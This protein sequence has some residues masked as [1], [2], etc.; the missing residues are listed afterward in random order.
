MNHE[1]NA[2]IAK[3]DCSL[4]SKNISIADRINIVQKEL[5]KVF[6]IN[7]D[8]DYL[9]TKYILLWIDVNDWYVNNYKI[10]IK[11]S[12]FITKKPFF[13]QGDIYYIDVLQITEYCNISDC[14]NLS[15]VVIQDLTE[16]EIKSLR[17]QFKMAKSQWESINNLQLV[18]DYR[19]ERKKSKND[20]RI[21]DELNN[22]FYLPPETL[23]LISLALEDLNL[24]IVTLN[25]TSTSNYQFVIFP[26]SQAIEKLLKACII[27]EKLI[28][29]KE[30]TEL[31]EILKSIK[32][33]HKLFKLI[34][35]FNN[36]LP[37]P[38]KIKLEINKFL[39]AKKMFK[40]S[41]SNPR[42]DVMKVSPKQAVDII[43]ANLNI[44]ELVSEKFSTP[45][46]RVM[47][48]PEL[49]EGYKEYFAQLEDDDFFLEN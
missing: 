48:Y 16:E 43:D 46:Y 3:I 13:L 37:S 38:D 10:K 19:D 8:Y 27:S 26:A 7:I 39:N 18:I 14:T 33:G 23:D 5:C 2:Q 45:L 29:G 44:F 34:K 11:F 28:L 32:Y 40:S 20:L 25:N 41:D 30:V 31:L 9:D 36:V 21:P 24:A 1:I 15:E 6:N 12:N 22:D 4:R 49:E 47:Y 17:K 42:Y 35:D